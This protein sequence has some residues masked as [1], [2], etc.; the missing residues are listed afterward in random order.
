MISRRIHIG[1]IIK[2]ELEKQGRKP[3]WLAKQLCFERT[4]VYNI[5]RRSTIDTELLMRI[6]ELLQV[7]FFA[8]YSDML[9]NVQ[10]SVE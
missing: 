9:K 10:Q 3:S 6:S 8:L 1:S 2:N 4:N 7:D 5:F